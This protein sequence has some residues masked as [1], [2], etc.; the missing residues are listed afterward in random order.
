MSLSKQWVT[1]S[2]T[3]ELDR[4]V[5]P[6][7]LVAYDRSCDASTSMFYFANDH[8]DTRGLNGKLLRPFPGSSNKR[9]SIWLTELLLKDS[10]A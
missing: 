7:V 4:V 5:S 8:V 10:H 9:S 2:F 1:K 3:T 6:L